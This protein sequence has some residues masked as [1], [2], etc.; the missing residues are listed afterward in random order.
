MPLISTR[1]ASA[2]GVVNV[3]CDRVKIGC[4]VQG[5]KDDWI[6]ELSFR[7]EVLDNVPRGRSRTR[8]IAISQ[9]TEGFRSWI[10]GAGLGEHDLRVEEG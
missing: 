2:G 3:F 5:S 6:W 9:I 4:F 1:P 7:S 8:E 10:R